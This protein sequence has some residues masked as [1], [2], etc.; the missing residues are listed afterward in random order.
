MVPIHRPR[1]LR[2]GVCSWSLRPTGVEDLIAKVRRTG[3][4]AVQLALEPLRADPERWADAGAKLAEAGIAPCSGMFQPTGEDYTTPATIR[5]TGGLVPDRTWAENRSRAAAAAAAAA[6]LGLDRVSFHA[7]FIPEECSS[8]AY[9]ALVERV[10]L[11]ADTFAAGGAALL[12]ETGQETAAALEAFLDALDRPEVGVNFDPANMLL[13]DMGDPIAA[14]RRLLTRVRQLHLKDARRPRVPGAWGEEV[15]L[16]TGEVDWTALL[17]VVAG[18]GFEGPA[19]VEREAG[20]DR[21]GDVRAAVAF[22][23]SAGKGAGA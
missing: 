10:R 14:L 19:V 5:A 3:L 8:A 20:G 16:G 18:A 1:R 22:L 7:G 2:L 6:R 23:A 12:L 11:V 13:Y 17:A 21:V 9:A 4:A 15:V